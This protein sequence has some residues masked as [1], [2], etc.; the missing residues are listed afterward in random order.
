M[1]TESKGTCEEVFIIRDFTCTPKESTVQIYNLKLV[2]SDYKID[3]HC[4]NP[5]SSE[6]P[7]PPISKTFFLPFCFHFMNAE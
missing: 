6:H 7:F 5:F 2:R 4:A 1:N 3:F